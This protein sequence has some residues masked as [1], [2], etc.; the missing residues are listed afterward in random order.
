MQH[1]MRA[2]ALQRVLGTESNVSKDGSRAVSLQTNS[3]YQMYLANPNNYGPSLLNT[4]RN[5]S[6]QKHKQYGGGASSVNASAF[7][8]TNSNNRRNEAIRGVDK[9]LRRKKME[10]EERRKRKQGDFLKCVL[11]HRDLFLKFHKNKRNGTKSLC[12]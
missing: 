8:F 1:R 9:D 4:W 3:V 11:N 7:G 10:I 6:K 2:Q 12:A 5:F